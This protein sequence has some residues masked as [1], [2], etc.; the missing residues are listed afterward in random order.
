MLSRI[1]GAK[2]DTGPSNHSSFGRSPGPIVMGLD[3]CSSSQIVKWVNVLHAA[4]KREIWT[5]VSGSCETVTWRSVRD[6]S[7]YSVI[8]AISS[9]LNVRLFKW[10]LDKV[11]RQVSMRLESRVLPSENMNARDLRRQVG[12]GSGPAGQKH[13]SISR[14]VSEASE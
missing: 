5:L 9:E 8:L 3:W 13:Q 14:V 6:G 12:L 11:S 10:R 2:Y 1:I 7:G 4:S